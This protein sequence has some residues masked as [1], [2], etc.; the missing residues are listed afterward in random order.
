MTN[1]LQ[2]QCTKHVKIDVHFIREHVAID[3]IHVLQV[4]T[5]SQFTDI[6]TEDLSFPVFLEFQSSMNI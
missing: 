1:T 3:G 5:I 6:F 2:H 4:L